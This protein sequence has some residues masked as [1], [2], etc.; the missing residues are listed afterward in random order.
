MLSEA[1]GIYSL[2]NNVCCIPISFFHFKYLF[3]T[4]CCL[5]KL[6]HI[7]VP[8]PLPFPKAVNV[9]FS[10]TCF[11]PQAYKESVKRL[12]EEL[13]LPGNFGYTHD[14]LFFLSFAQV[15]SLTSI[16]KTISINFYELCVVDIFY[17]MTKDF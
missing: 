10:S 3:Q 14:Q 16:L 12:G 1:S 11:S 8:P 17:K 15:S 9:V 6:P 7:S 4:T 13:E 2:R 5:L